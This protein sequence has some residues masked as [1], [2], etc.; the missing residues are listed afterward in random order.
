NPVIEVGLLRA[1]AFV[2]PC[3]IYLLHLLC[4]GGAIYTL[5]FV[6]ADRPGGSAAQVGIVS[7][8]VYAASALGSP[9][10]GKLVDIWD[11]RK[12]LLGAMALTLLGLLLFTR[13]GAETPLWTVV[14]IVVM[15]GLMTG[16]KTPAI[17]KI[18]LG[19]IPEQRM[20]RGTG[21]MTMLRDLGA[22]AGSA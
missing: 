8:S 16:A 11:P 13:I 10:A 3:C 7:F 20:G 18:A 22:P 17:M 15:L 12:V 6:I 5:A 19:A 4:Y 2:L 9:I 21:L 14:A 1:P